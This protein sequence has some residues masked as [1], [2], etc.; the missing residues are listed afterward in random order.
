MA[1]I[2]GETTRK[3]FYMYDE[4]RKPSP[5]PE[6]KKFIQK[7]REISGVNVD[8]KVS[9]SLCACFWFLSVTIFPRLGLCNEILYS[10][11]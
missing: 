6:I 2:S 3:G 8:P 4:K 9:L 1:P 7:A 5:D 11:G 10:T